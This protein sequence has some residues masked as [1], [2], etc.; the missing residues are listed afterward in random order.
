MKAKYYIYRNLHTKNFSVR[1]KG[2]V[3]DHVNSAILIG[4]TFNVS[5]KGRQRVLKER[6]KNVHAT[7]ACDDYYAIEYEHDIKD[8][9]YYN[10]YK[11]DKLVLTSLGRPISSYPFVQVKDNKAYCV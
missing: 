6:R 1:Y 2:K 8:E 10:L 4:C 3:I 7:I 11:H 9:V 5:E